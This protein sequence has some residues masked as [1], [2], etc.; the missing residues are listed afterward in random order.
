[1]IAWQYHLTSFLI[2]DCGPA[3]ARRGI[4]ADSLATRTRGT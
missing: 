1:M 3:A 4:S 2:D